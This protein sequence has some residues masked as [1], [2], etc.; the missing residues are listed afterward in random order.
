[1][2]AHKSTIALAVLVLAPMAYFAATAFLLSRSTFQM[3]G[4]PVSPDLR[5]ATEI[6]LQICP[7]LAALLMIMVSSLRDNVIERLVRRFMPHHRAGYLVTML[8]VNL[9]L[10]VAIAALTAAAIVSVCGRQLDAV[11]LST[12]LWVAF[13]FIVD[14]TL[15]GVFTVFLHAL[16]RRV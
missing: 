3:Y 5:T 16:T 13:E 1:M 2:V 7:M 12:L 9:C 14:I 11:R 10:A 15:V 6:T 4:F 8:A